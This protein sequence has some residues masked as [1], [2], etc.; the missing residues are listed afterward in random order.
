[1]RLYHKKQ[2]DYFT[3]QLRIERIAGEKNKYKNHLV[4]TLTKKQNRNLNIE[5]K[6]LETKFFTARNPLSSTHFRNKVTFNLLFFKQ[7]S[8]IV[9]ISFFFFNFIVQISV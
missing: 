7:T 8:N 6:S 4:D 9:C 5:T 2:L 1:M 3:I